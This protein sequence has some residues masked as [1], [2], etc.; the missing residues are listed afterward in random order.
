MLIS[1]VKVIVKV[2]HIFNL[3][4][5]AFD[6]IEMFKS[7]RLLDILYKPKFIGDRNYE[8]TKNGLEKVGDM[9]QEQALRSQLSEIERDGIMFCGSLLD[10]RSWQ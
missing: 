9:S 1:V 8:A 6:F 10:L 4:T 3:E 5:A 2:V 7:Q